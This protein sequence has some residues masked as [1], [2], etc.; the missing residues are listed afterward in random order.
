MNRCPTGV[1]RRIAE[2]RDLPA[3][4]E[5]YNSTVASRLVTADTEPVTVESRVPWFEAH[6]RPNRPLWVAEV[7]GEVAAWLSLS[8]FYGRPAYD[9][10]VEVSL[11]VHEAFR[12][13]K[14]GSFL[15]SEAISHAPSFGVETLIGFIF[16]HNQPSLT[17]FERFAFE[18][19]GHLPKVAEL[20]GIVRDVV[21]LGRHASAG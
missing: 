7:D 11:Y 19:W 5:I 16:G 2:R 4:V 1:T 3:I 17:L 18:R 10:T 15:L 9:K 20:D 13:R 8:T 21:I 14:L 6:S 12:R